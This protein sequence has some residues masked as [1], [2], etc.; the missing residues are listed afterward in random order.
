[1]GG[2]A[3]WGGAEGEEVASGDTLYREARE[4]SPLQGDGC[5][6]LVGSQRGRNGDGF[7]PP[8]AGALRF[9]EPFQE[10]LGVGWEHA[11]LAPGALGEALRAC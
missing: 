2:G 6:G 10:S 4:T 1:M 9:W 11:A 7:G 8:V 3:A 5:R